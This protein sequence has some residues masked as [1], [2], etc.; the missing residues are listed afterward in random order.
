[1]IFGVTLFLRLAQVLF[2]PPK[3]RFPCPAC[4]LQRHDSDAVHCKACGTRLAIPDEGADWSAHRTRRGEPGMNGNGAGAFASVGA[5]ICSSD[6]VVLE[7]VRNPFAAVPT[8]A[9]S[10]RPPGRQ[11]R[12]PHRMTSASPKRPDRGWRKP[13]VLAGLPS[14]PSPWCSSASRWRPASG[15]TWP[16]RRSRSEAA[17]QH[18]ILSESERLLVEHGRARDRHARLRAVR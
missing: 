5:V 6:P 8:S 9:P 10:S 12:E 17:R 7:P 16:A 4:G 13:R 11:P 3:V 2:R 1:M 14:S 15:T 18:A